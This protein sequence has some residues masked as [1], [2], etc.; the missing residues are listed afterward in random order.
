MQRFLIA[1]ATNA[2]AEALISNC[3]EQLA[4]VPQEANLGFV[5]AT[6]RLANEMEN[7][8]ALLQQM[9]PNLHWVGTVGMGLCFT[10]EE[11]YDCPAVAM[12]VGSFPEESFRVFP[13]LPADQNS[14]PRE[15]SDWWSGQ[16]FCFGLLHGDPTNP[17]TAVVLK[18]LS[19]QQP[20]GFFNGGLTSSSGANPQLADQVQHGGFSGV[21]FNDQVQIVTDHSQGC[22]PIGP[23]HEISQA[24]NNFAITLDGR[25]ALDVMKEDIGEILAKDLGGIGGY[26]F[27]AFPIQG[28]DSGDYLVRN[29]IGLDVDQGQVVIG[30]FL[31]D[32]PQM[33]FCQR[34]G[35][36]ARD[37]L[38]RMLQRLRERLGDRDIRGGIYLSCLGRG[39]YQ[40][41]VNSE[42]L[43]MI[44]GHLGD[45]PLVGFFA[46]GEIYNGRL[47]GYTGV[48]TLFL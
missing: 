11:I 22:T 28:T 3:L 24:K 2:P 39:R 46:N 37:D 45:F 32:K 25:P 31:E 6:D 16:E 27:A 26:I 48:L 5:Y 41:G 1:H 17:M 40:F 23:V 42:E 21:L 18:R 36:T 12:M 15:L 4:D 7:I 47:Y 9:L 19:E 8:L 43:K 13:R 30:D 44:A 20:P 10:G 29:L 38:E 14:L 34:D 33:M 35:N